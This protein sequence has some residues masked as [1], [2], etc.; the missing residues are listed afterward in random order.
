[1]RIG[2]RA[3]VKEV[4]LTPMEAIMAGQALLFC[5]TVDNSKPG[6]IEPGQALFLNMP[7]KTTCEST[8]D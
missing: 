2:A 1:M 6:T 3:G 7:G 8:N 4:G 5:V